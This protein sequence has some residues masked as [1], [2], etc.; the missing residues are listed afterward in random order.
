MSEFR[1]NI[2]VSAIVSTYN[3]ER[4]IAGCL[5]D[6]VQQSHFQA[7]KVEILVIDC[8]SPGN[9]GAIVRSFQERY[10]NISYLRLS[11]R[12]TLYSAWNIG[13]GLARGKYITNA[14]TDDR[15][16]ADAYGR[17]A[18]ELDSNPDLDLVYGDVFVSFE[19]NQP[20]H[21]NNGAVVYRYPDYSPPDALLFCQIGCQPMWR[22]SVHGYVGLFRADMKAAGDHEFNIRLALAGRQLKHIPEV[23][24]SFL[25]RTDSVS[26]GD[27]TSFQEQATLRA[28]YINAENIRLLCTHAKRELSSL[29]DQ[30][31]AFKS[32]AL[33]SLN[34]PLPWHPGETYQDPQVFETCRTEI[35]RIVRSR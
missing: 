7:G 21:A 9:E 5:E 33:R 18:M 8:A 17:M 25:E 12:E 1:Q 19:P 31:E 16:R 23:L 6:L 3:S 29:R 20:F 30:V 4:F 11:E 2:E 14:N 24:G 10:P 27:S 13:I 32:V 26:K 15:H 22:K 28:T 34:F 35:D